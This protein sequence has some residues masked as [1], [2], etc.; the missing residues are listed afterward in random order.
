[1]NNTPHAPSKT[2]TLSPLFLDIKRQATTG[3]W[4]RTAETVRSGGGSNSEQFNL[5][6]KCQVLSSQSFGSRV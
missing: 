6:F 3:R 5:H 1:M 4:R 2:P